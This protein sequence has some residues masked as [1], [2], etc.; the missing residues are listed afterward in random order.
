MDK[1]EI[2]K[3]ITNILNRKN[4]QGDGKH[5]EID[6]DKGFAAFITIDFDNKSAVRIVVVQ[7]CFAFWEILRQ[8]VISSNLDV[9]AATTIER[10]FVENHISLF[11]AGI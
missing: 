5:Y 10:V 3:A 2:Q 1:I 7:D 6:V 9:D 8:E 4:E 11:G